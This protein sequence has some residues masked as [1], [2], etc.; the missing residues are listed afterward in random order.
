MRKLSKPLENSIDVFNLCISRVK[1]T[2][3]KARLVACEQSIHDAVE[4]YDTKAAQA[5]LHTI[6]RHDAVNLNVTQE[7][8]ESIYTGRMV[9]QNSPGREVYDKLISSAPNNI[10]PLCSQ[11]VVNTLEHHLPKK[12]FPVYSVVPI[13]LFPC[14][15]ACNKSKLAFFPDNQ[16]EEPI[17]P[18]YDDFE[19]ALW[20]KAE[21]IES[22][23]PSV[24]YY[25]QKPHDWTN[26]K[27]NRINNHFE[28]MQLGSLYA[29]HSGVELA[30]IKYNMCFLF[31]SGGSDS[32]K[33]SL[34]RSYLSY[35]EFNLN[36]W[37]AALYYA[38]SNSEW[39]VNGGFNM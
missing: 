8:M 14:C 13:N 33:E 31:D 37:K 3:L 15:S 19:D 22:D 36:S 4:I 2:E 28:L 27:Y 9:G 35:K 30:E 23:I 10:C 5:E 18:Y 38:L 25:T 1:S 20:L 26:V 39:Y 29:S 11:R 16:N 6:E 32:V 24:M 17:H 34:E 12:H 7:E 21:V